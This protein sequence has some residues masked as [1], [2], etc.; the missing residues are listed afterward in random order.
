MKFIHTADWQAVLWGI[1]DGK[2]GVDFKKPL[3][4]GFG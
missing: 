1:L 4:S 2:P 3:S